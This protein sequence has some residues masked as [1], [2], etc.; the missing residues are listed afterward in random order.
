MI[1]ETEVVNLYVQWNFFPNSL[2]IR[3][4]ICRL[5][6]RKR[7]YISIRVINFQKIFNQIIKKKFYIEKVPL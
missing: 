5:K 1:E 7:Y 3:F 6:I 4:E 2:E